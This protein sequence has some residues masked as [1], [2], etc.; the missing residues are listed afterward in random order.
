MTKE[1]RVD[2]ILLAEADS[3]RIL[4]QNVNPVPHSQIYLTNTIMY[5]FLRV[6]SEDLGQNNYI[7]DLILQYDIVNFDYN[8]II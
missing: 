3:C 7:F 5:C 2:E 8:L 1:N 6:L 4:L